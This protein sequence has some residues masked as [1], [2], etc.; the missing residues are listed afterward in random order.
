MPYLYLSIAIICEVVGTVSLKLSDGFTKP[1]YTTI[2][3]IGWGIA[4]YLLAVC[5]RYFSVGF[6]YA[7]W[8]GLG[9][10]LVALIGVLF[11][12]EWADWQGVLGLGFI[13][14]GVV[15]LNSFSRMSGH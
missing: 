1:L 8:A 13:V 2:T 5:L 4:I 6:T 11:L 10:V 9:I 7:V 14:T 3:L 15:V 12:G